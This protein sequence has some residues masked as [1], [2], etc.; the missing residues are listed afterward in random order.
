MMQ[1]IQS[2]RD[3]LA[4]L[5]AA[6]KIHQRE[7]K[8]MSEDLETEL[9]SLQR[10]E[11]MFEEVKKESEATQGR[12]NFLQKSIATLRAR[13]EI[14]RIDHT[15]LRLAKHKV[16]RIRGA[17]PISTPVAGSRATTPVSSFGTGG[18]F[19]GSGLSRPSFS[20][21]SLVATTL[22]LQLS[23]FIHGNESAS[24]S[25]DEEDPINTKD[26]NSDLDNVIV[27]GTSNPEDYD[28]INEGRAVDKM[29]DMLSRQS[30]S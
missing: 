25:D 28:D 11:Q 17:S 27:K 8:T 20:S 15:T 18:T 14:N 12:V 24:S 21:R 4:S 7:L 13:P 30:E 22:D 10:A 23:G 19:S 1:K 16:P 6:A 5:T 9:A 2:R 26:R 3:H 29:D